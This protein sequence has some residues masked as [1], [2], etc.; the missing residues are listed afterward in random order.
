MQYLCNDEFIKKKDV[1]AKYESKFGEPL[2][3]S[4]L[5]SCFSRIASD[6]NSKILKRIY[7]G[8]Y[9]FSD[10]SMGHRTKRILRI[11]RKEY[12]TY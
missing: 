10:P 5:D 6:D 4:A 7:K 8:V 2:M 3:R 11:E 1:K 12:Q 9:R